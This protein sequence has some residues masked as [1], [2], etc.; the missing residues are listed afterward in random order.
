MFG[1]TYRFQ[2]QLPHQR[3]YTRVLPTLV[4]IYQEEGP[5]ALYKGFIP[6]ALRLGL[7]Q[8]VGLVMF[9]RLLKAFHVE[10][11]EQYIKDVEEICRES[12]ADV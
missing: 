12:L 1:T 10:D 8:S 9:Q 3:K 4:T 11:E 2:S 6:K 5:R 7:G